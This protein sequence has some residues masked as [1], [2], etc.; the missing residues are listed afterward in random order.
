MVVVGVVG[1]VVRECWSLCQVLFDVIAAAGALLALLLLY[2]PPCTPL[3]P[4]LH[5][6]HYVCCTCV[7]C[8][9]QALLHMCVCVC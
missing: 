8:L 3:S 7:L 1:V 6:C 5:D 2:I 4:L 9:D